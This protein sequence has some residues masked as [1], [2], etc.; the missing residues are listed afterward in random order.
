MTRVGMT[1]VERVA[2]ALLL[3]CAILV[4][5]GSA[6]PAEEEPLRMTACGVLTGKGAVAAA[7]L[8][9]DGCRVVRSWPCKKNSY[10][11]VCQAPSDAPGGGLGRI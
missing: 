9:L 10:C 6:A 1:R 5:V 3:G 7:D 8:S 11:P 4:A 2:L